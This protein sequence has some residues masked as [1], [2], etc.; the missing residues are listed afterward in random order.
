MTHNG[1]C[2]PSTASH[3]GFLS[4]THSSPDKPPVGSVAKLITIYQPLNIATLS[5]IPVELGSVLGATLVRSFLAAILKVKVVRLSS[6]CPLFTFSFPILV[7]PIS[8]L[9]ISP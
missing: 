8:P 9:L 1:Y 7:H 6:F 4:Y 3:A 5:S 2:L